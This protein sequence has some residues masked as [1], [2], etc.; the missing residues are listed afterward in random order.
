MKVGVVGAGMGGLAAAIESA[1]RGHEVVVWEL[2]ERAGGKVG[3]AERDGVEFDTGPSV[4]TMLE[5][6]EGLFER[7]DTR[8]EDELELVTPDPW[9]RYMY[10]DGAELDIHHDTEATLE[11]VESTFGR[12]ASGEVAD[13]LEYAERIWEAAAPNFVFSQ[14]PSIGGMMRLGLS[15][16]GDVM[17]IDPMR[18]MWSSITSRISDPR[19]QWLFARYATYVGAD[20]RKAPATMNCISWVELGGRACGIDGGMYEMVRALERVARGLGVEFRYET[21]VESL[22][23]RGGQVREVATSGGTEQVDAAVVN[24]GVHHLVEDLVDDGRLAGLESSQ[25]N[26]T[27]GWTVVIR[28]P[29]RT[30][31]ERAPHTVVFPDEYIEEFVDLFDR[32]RR[33]DDPTI[34]LC[35]QEKSHGREGWDDEEPIFAMVNTPPLP[36]EGDAGAR[37]DHWAELER[38]VLDRLQSTGLIGDEASVTWRR[39]PD[40]LAGRF[41][42]S[43]GSIYGAAANSRFAAFQRPPNRVDAVDGLYLAS[44]SAHPGGGVPMC[45]QSGR[46]AAKA[47]DEDGPP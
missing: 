27:S 39:T 44:G 36:E 11:S 31:S 47:L 23:A 26:S 13:F 37:S 42:G 35:A 25:P 43:R 29:R 16:P 17:A 20:P 1:A 2:G 9:F 41:P 24:A 5:V 3:I 45:L 14:A 22:E 40:E 4:M 15:A 12:E 28:A 8:L 6:L 30:K 32:D 10:P 21:R 38:E 19:L 33:P 34:Y 18:T 46:L 7:A